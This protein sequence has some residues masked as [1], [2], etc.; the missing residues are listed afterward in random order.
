[1]ESTEDGT[2]GVP[3]ESNWD[4]TPLKE[5]REGWGGE[6]EVSKGKMAVREE[7]TRVN[8]LSSAYS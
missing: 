8:D 7:C 2:T 3:K 5:K 1:M 4:R 6:K